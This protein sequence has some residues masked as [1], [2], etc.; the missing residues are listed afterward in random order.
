MSGRGRDVEPDFEAF[1]DCLNRHHVEYL[2]VG[3]ET[4]AVHGVQR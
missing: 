1:C 4:V 3:S 2:I